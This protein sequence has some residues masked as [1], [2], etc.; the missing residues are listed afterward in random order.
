MTHDIDTRDAIIEDLSARL[1]AA[2]AEVE[3]LKAQIEHMWKE[4][5]DDA[6]KELPRLRWQADQYVQ[7][8]AAMGEAQG[9]DGVAIKVIDRLHE[10]TAAQERAAIVAWLRSDYR[11]QT[12]FGAR[13][14]AGKHWPTEGEKP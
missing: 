11:W 4:S 14:E 1:E 9:S 5:S 6:A 12:G 10:P 13:I 7:I 2:E 8:C 3:R